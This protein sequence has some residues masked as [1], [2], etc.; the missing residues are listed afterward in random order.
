MATRYRIRSTESSTAIE[1][2]REYKGDLN[3]VAKKA[4]RDYKKHSNTA[5]TKLEIVN[6]ETE[7]VYYVDCSVWEV[8][9]KKGKNGSPYQFKDTERKQERDRKYFN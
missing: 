1:M 4:W 3:L 7:E 9:G 2:I 8:A 6:C 5:A